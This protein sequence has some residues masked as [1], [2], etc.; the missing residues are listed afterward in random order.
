MMCIY[1]SY[2]CPVSMLDFINRWIEAHEKQQHFKVIGNINIEDMDFG[3][4]TETI[5]RKR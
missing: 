3:V 4:I 1:P 2:M 5:K